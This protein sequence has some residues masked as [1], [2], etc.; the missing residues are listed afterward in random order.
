MGRAPP[1]F[2]ISIAGDEQEQSRIQLEKNL[3]HTD[4]SLHLS[5]THDDFSVE[6]PRHHSS[7][8]AP[9]SAFNSIDPSRD[10]LDM[11]EGISQLHAW[12]YRTGEDDEGVRPFVGGETLSTAA[13]HASALTLSAGLAGRGE[14]RDISLSGA[15]Y[16][17]DR[18]LQ[19]LIAG[20]G[21]QFSLLGADQAPSR[22]ASNSMPIDPRIVDSMTEFNRVLSTQQARAAARHVRSPRSEQSTSSS[23]SELD[24]PDPT[25][26]PKLSDA[27]SHLMLSP[28]RPRSPALRPRSASHTYAPAQRPIPSSSRFESQQ[29]PQSH[30]LNARSSSLRTVQPD[31]GEGEPT[32]RPRKIKPHMPPDN[33]LR[34]PTPST[35]NS[36]FTRLARGL[37]R[38]IEVEQSR[39]HAPVEI[40]GLSHVGPKESGPTQSA[41]RTKA[42]PP[43]AF[44]GSSNA[45]QKLVQ[46][47]DVT[48]LTVAVESPA[49]GQ[50]HQSYGNIGKESEDPNG[51]ARLQQAM[52]LLQKKIAHLDTEN[53]TSRKRMKEL[54]HELDVCRQ[55]VERQRTLVAQRED[56]LVRQQRMEAAD[57]R[58]KGKA[59]AI[60]DAR[61]EQKRYK[62]SVEEKKALESLIATLRS[63]MARLTSELAT[64]KALLDELR[65]LREADK[66]TLRQ[67]VR[68]VDLLRREVEK[69]AGEVEVLKG[70]VEEGLR[71]RRERSLSNSHDGPQDHGPDA[72]QEGNLD[73]SELGEGQDED[74]D[75]SPNSQRDADDY[76][77]EDVQPALARRALL[78]RTIRTDHATFGSTPMTGNV[79]HTRRYV[80]HDEVERIS[81][82]LEERRSERS[83]SSSRLGSSL[84]SNGSHRA[85]SVASSIASAR[86]SRIVE[87]PV[88]RAATPDSIHRWERVSSP[89]PA[90][91]VSRPSAPTPAHAARE[92]PPAGETPFPQIRGARLERMF[93]SA[94]EHN[95]KTCTVCHRRRHYEAPQRPL[96][97]PASKGRRVTVADVGEEDEGFEEG[98]IADGERGHG[99]TMNLDFLD[100][101]SGSDKLPPQTVLVR[102]LRELE[103]DFT[104][105]KGIYTELAD[106][107]K[108][109]DP[110]SNVVKRNVL[111]QHLREVIDVLEQRGDQIASL[112]DLL[113][114]EDKPVARS[115]V[116][117]KDCSKHHTAPT[118]SERTR[119]AGSRKRLTFA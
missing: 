12:S 100:K 53:H 105:Y 61:V 1:K 60:E 109:M 37:A 111:A 33:A 11:D 78:E 32:P 106:Q 6:N 93:F 83:R 14:R 36:H 49:K 42:I 84:S 44:V 110:A 54:E 88:E 21:S 92:R 51:H 102:V 23:S 18:P 38:E 108:V 17:P 41:L 94:P 117:E 43:N 45:K 59:R 81:V 65:T 22:H 8:S 73:N 5:S 114:F 66:S 28:K 58:T 67:K 82:E 101:G 35:A 75:G 20:M 89:P 70:V 79:G 77:I 103:D 48:G 64:H 119:Q 56:L 29:P 26:K 13:H 57:S 86:S 97:Y 76:E 62:Q 39:W 98:S 68:E 72:S 52:N 30:H 115:V 34:P 74:E 15:E 107:Y 7:V 50:S 104:H 24:T 27:L 4:L 113:T 116:P 87:S 90:V 16:D 95:A 31:V 25:S 71:E 96:W 118:R 40:E 91:Q 99:A 85:P 69:I 3:L 47:P 9:F 10:A 19:D 46:L 80:D 112:Y 2:D 55:D 63:H